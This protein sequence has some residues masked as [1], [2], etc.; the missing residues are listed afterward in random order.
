MPFFVI[1]FN[2]IVGFM[3]DVLFLVENLGKLVIIGGL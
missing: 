3:P 1:E 2:G